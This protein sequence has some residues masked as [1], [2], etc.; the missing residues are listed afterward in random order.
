MME[1]EEEEAE[2]F[3][4]RLESASLEDNGGG[5]RMHWSS[6]SCNEQGRYR[7]QEDRVVHYSDV[8]AEFHRRVADGNVGEFDDVAPCSAAIQSSTTTGST[9]GYFGVFD[10][11]AG[12]DGSI[13]VSQNLHMDIMRC[14]IFCYSC[15]IHE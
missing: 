9:M 11:H 10:G 12:Q 1:E 3:R 14:V 5:R 2:R 7:Y 15:E 8:I 13:F 6:G 4:Q